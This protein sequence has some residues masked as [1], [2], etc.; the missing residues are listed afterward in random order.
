MI[1]AKF[2]DQPLDL[3]ATL[4]PFGFENAATTVGGAFLEAWGLREH[5]RPESD[6]HLG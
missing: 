4:A 5:E 6:Q 1:A 3:R 2:L